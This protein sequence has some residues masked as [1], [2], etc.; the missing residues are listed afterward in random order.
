MINKRYVLTA[1]HCY[2]KIPK[3]WTLSK[4]RLGEWDQRTN[5]D[6]QEIENEVICNENYVEV[7][8]AEVIVHPNY[9]SFRAAQYNDIALLKLEHDV[10]YTNW[11][12]PICLPIDSEIR[13]MDVTSHTLEVAGFGL[14]ETGFSSEVKKKVFLDGILQ[15]HC[16]RSFA[17]RGVK[18]FDNQVSA[19]YYVY[20][21]SV[22]KRTHFE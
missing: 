12:K 21:I 6:C 2:R 19:Q 4:V 5:P 14:T 17:A 15:A 13:T 11:I 1:A 3:S 18:I 7:P 9:T 10:A 16:Q 22:S 8:V 20:S